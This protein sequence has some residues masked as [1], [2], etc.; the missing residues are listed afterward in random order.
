VT[1]AVLEFEPRVEL[2]NSQSNVTPFPDEN[3]FEINL[4]FRIPSLSED[5]FE[6][7]GNFE[8]EL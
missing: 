5:T 4:F 7:T 2:D 8:A 3:R 1:D 6:F